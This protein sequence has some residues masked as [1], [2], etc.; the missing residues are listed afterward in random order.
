MS[1][2]EYSM[3][4]LFLSIPFKHFSQIFRFFYIYSSLCFNVSIWTGLALFSYLGVGAG[5]HSGLCREH[6]TSG[7]NVDYCGVG[8][9]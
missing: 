5:H 8:Y 9:K 4:L 1:A 7:V 2:P 6:D 3:R